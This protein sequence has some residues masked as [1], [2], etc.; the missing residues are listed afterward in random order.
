M[1]RL[2][3]CKTWQ[4]MAQTPVEFAPR[5]NAARGVDDPLKG[6]VTAVRNAAKAAMKSV[7]TLF[8]VSEEDYCAD[9]KAMAPAMRS[10]VRLT[11]AFSRAY[12]VEKARRNVMDFSDQ[13]HYAITLLTGE[14]G[15]PSETAQR[16]ARRYR[17][18]MVDEYQDS[19]AVQESIFNAVSQAGRNLF[20]V[21]DVKQSI[22]RFRL[23]DPGI[24]LEKYLAYR[25]ARQAEEGQ[26]RRVLLSQNFRSRQEIL[27]AT[28]F[29]F[30]N[31]M[32]RE[33]GNWNTAKTSSSISV[34]SI[35]CPA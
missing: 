15:A 10:L 27:Q 23:A 6:Q 7:R 18:I 13:E 1:E 28:N 33:M 21:G 32:S 8:S 12:Q 22:Y 31:I 24:F 30:R 16:I 14:N 34:Q 2:A 19:N 11:V 17:E 20:T 35:I 29:V 5:L 26:P 4:E 3:A 9:L 25:N